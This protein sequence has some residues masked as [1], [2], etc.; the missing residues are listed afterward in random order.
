MELGEAQGRKKALADMLLR[1]LTY[2][3]GLLDPSLRERIRA[4]TDV[5]AL[6]AWWQEVALTTDAEAARR[7]ADKIQKALAA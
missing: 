6:D 3:L 2:R 4:C 1:I 5:D 7:L